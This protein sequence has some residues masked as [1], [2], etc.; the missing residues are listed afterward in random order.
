MGCMLVCVC[1]CVCVRERQR[2]VC[3]GCLMG[4]HFC[5]GTL[6]PVRGVLQPTTHTR[7]KPVRFSVPLYVMYKGH[8]PLL[9]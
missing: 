5:R 1:V 8:A 7:N 3:V 6:S 2:E 4:A 9:V